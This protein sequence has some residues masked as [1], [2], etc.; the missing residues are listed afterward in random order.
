[1]HLSSLSELS[2]YPC[3]C[4]RP[5]LPPIHSPLSFVQKGSG[6]SL[7]MLLFLQQWESRLTASYTYRARAHYKGPVS[8]TDGHGKP[9]R[10]STEDQSDQKEADV[11][12]EE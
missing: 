1:M 9:T 8:Y 2:R 12:V 4:P 5:P 6:I 7:G 11:T 3:A 10:G